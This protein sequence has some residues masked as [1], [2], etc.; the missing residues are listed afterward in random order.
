MDPI[1]FPFLARHSKVHY[2]SISSTLYNYSKAARDSRIPAVPQGSGPEQAEIARILGC[3][4]SYGGPV[5]SCVN[6]EEGV[7]ELIVF[8]SLGAGL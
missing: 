3:P 7:L 8:F 4:Q 2:S 6:T 5:P 1:T